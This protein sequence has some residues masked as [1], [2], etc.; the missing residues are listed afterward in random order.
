[1]KPDID[2]G[3]DEVEIVD[4]VE[5]RRIRLRSGEGGF[6][7]SSAV[8]PGALPFPV[9]AAVRLSARRLTVPRFV[10]LFVRDESGAVVAKTGPF[11]YR[12]LPAD[13]YVV[14]IHAPIK[15]YL[16]VE[17][18]FTLAAGADEIT[19]AFDDASTV[20]LGARSYHERP[21]ATIT[22][23]DD[24]T[25]LQTAVSYLGS[26]LKTTGPE[27][28]YPTLRGH[29]PLFKRGDSLDVPDGLPEPRDDVRL[30]VPPTLSATFTVAPLS[31]YLGCEVGPG[32]GPKLVTDRGFEYPLDGPAGYEESVE[33]LLKQVFFLDA[34]VRAEGFSGV[35]LAER[36]AFDPPT[37]FDAERLYDLSLP[38]RLAAY[39][40][41]PF[42]AV[43][44]HLPRWEL[45]A[46]LPPEPDHLETLPFVVDELAVVRT[47]R[48]ERVPSAVGREQL[49]ERY[50]E[51]GHGSGDEGA[52]RG[53]PLA[54]GARRSADGAPGA[55]EEVVW[56]PESD[57]VEQVWFG[58][59]LPHNASKGT[60]QA[61]RNRLD[62][63]PGKDDIDITV[64]CNGTEMGAEFDQ[65]TETYGSR[66]ELPFAVTIERNLSTAELRRRLTD[67]THF[68]H[69]IGHIDE[70]GF[71]CSDGYLDAGGLD[72][73][74][75]DAF[76][77][78]ACRS[79]E[80][81]VDLVD[82]GAIGGVVTL[83]DVVSGSATRVGCTVARLL[84][85]G[86][87]LRAALA[88]AREETFVGGYYLVVGDGTVDVTQVEH[89]MPHVCRAERVDA[90]TVSLAF[91]TYLPAE[92]GM[93]SVTY[94]LVPSRSSYHLAP[95]EVG[96][97]HVSNREAEEFL[98]RFSPPVRVAGDLVWRD[99]YERI[100]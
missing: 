28:S 90:E 37:E 14:E 27:R 76:L 97:F 42:D 7:D 57:A 17:S 34:L 26:A 3:G 88:Q 19:L 53:E 47:S 86:F 41:V 59:G 100:T 35:D 60:P 23:T 38:G 2:V 50:L 92:G 13:S 79:Y 71:R 94:P 68:L 36:A 9:D 58:D 31:Y 91:D 74:G 20:V 54:G 70:Q 1:M 32:E 55:D 67:E 69:Y 80:Q 6:A 11:D 43:E 33:R 46:W 75:I 30:E 44:P 48:P 62:H 87:P 24:P 96:P 10:H 89:G 49:F 84:N 63:Q 66:A 21:A 81:G 95:G 8:D 82:A 18:S 39:L 85:I 65:V 61:Y 64:V 99:A 52:T 22:T 25:D 72:S 78:N 45:V 77:L 5:R 29:P 4:P 93:G 73:V 16:R 15:L 83:D 12:E 56:V 40:S 98:T 51:D